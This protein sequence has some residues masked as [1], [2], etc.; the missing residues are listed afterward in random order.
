M[1]WCASDQYSKVTK[2]SYQARHRCGSE[3]NNNYDVTFRWKMGN[4][5]CQHTNVRLSLGGEI[6]EVSQREFHFADVGFDMPN[7]GL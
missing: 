3:G 7:I 2:Q 1:D 4:A 6:A 5:F